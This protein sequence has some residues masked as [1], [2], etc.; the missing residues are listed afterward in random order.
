MV[1]IRKPVLRMG[2]FSQVCQVLDGGGIP[3]Y[4][5]AGMK[6]VHW[7]GAQNVLVQLLFL[8]VTL[9]LFV[10]FLMVEKLVGSSVATLAI[11]VATLLAV[12]S[13]KMVMPK[14]KTV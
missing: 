4:I 9:P 10:V 12:K 13:S 5:S 7:V 14:Q 8:L 11:F 6:L 3:Y 1:L 2:I